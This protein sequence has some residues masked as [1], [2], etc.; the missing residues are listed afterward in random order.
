LAGLQHVNALDRIPQPAFIHEVEPVTLLVALDEH[1]E[2][3]KE[4]LQVLFGLRQRERVDGEV[5]RLLTDIQVRAAENRGKGLEARADIE[6]EGQRS[7]L[8]RVLQQEGARVRFA[9]P[10][11]SENQ[12]MG[13]LAAIQVQEVGRAVVGFE[14]SQVP[15]TEARVRLLAGKVGSSSSCAKPSPISP[16]F[17]PLSRSKP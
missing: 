12:R 11:H 6:D 1:A 2:E 16:R 14:H 3:G 4:K 7:L 8:L 17:A 10:G 15:R 13:D 9:T 5:S